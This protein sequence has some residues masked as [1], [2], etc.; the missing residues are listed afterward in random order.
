[1]LRYLFDYIYTKLIY[2]IRI[3]IYT[4]NLVNNIMVLVYFPC[5]IT[6]KET[7]MY[8]LYE[9]SS[10]TLKMQ[11]DRRKKRILIFDP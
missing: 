8:C 9:Q 6:K 5:K 10:F 3:Q 2:Q 4:L 11:P 7:L 1:M